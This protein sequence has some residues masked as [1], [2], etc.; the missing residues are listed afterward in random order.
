MKKQKLIKIS[1][2]EIDYFRANPPKV[3]KMIDESDGMTYIDTYIKSRKVY[4][5]KSRSI[6]DEEYIDDGEQTLE[7]YINDF[8]IK[9]TKS[10]E[11]N[12]LRQGIKEAI[13]KQQMEEIINSSPSEKEHSDEVGSPKVL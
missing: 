4:K 2:K 1:K 7:G 11:D 10:V 6:E 5:Y 3:I 12:W 13:F 9:D 8:L